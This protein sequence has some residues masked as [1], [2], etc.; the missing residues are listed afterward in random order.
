M[1]DDKM[2][3][4]YI[5]ERMP[6]IL[7]TYDFAIYKF[8]RSITN[9]VNGFVKTFNDAFNGLTDEQKEEI[10]KRAKENVENK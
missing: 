8:S 1:N 2:I 9:F 4:D 3:A 5:K 7:N 6:E 10:T